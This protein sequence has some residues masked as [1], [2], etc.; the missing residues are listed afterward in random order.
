MLYYTDHEILIGCAF[1]RIQFEFRKAAGNMMAGLQCW[2]N[3]GGSRGQSGGG[4]AEGEGE[5]EPPYIM[6]CPYCNMIV[7]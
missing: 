5:A 2:R 1:T 4:G 6:T 7:S 3:R